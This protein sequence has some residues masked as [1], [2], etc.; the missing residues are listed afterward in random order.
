MMLRDIVNEKISGA[1]VEMKTNRKWRA[2]KTVTEVESR[3]RHSDLVGTTTTDR[4]GWGCQAGGRL[5]YQQGDRWSE[6]QKS[7]TGKHGS[8]PRW[9]GVHARNVSWNEMLKMYQHRLSATS[10]L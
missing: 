1:Q 5:H 8:S 7:T 4:L 10:C 9:E 6:Q 3:L 2:D